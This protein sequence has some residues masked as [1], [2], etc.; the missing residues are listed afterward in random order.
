M[1][2][3]TSW[4]CLAPTLVWVA[5][6]V[7]V[8]SEIRRLFFPNTLKLYQCSSLL[9]KKDAIIFGFAPMDV[10]VG[11]AAFLSGIKF[12]RTIATGVSAVYCNRLCFS[13]VG[14]DTPFCLK[15]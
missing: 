11:L 8:P 5:I 4:P 7:L 13:Y 3:F 1:A 14:F 6:E 2:Y 15:I 12:I 10:C 9:C